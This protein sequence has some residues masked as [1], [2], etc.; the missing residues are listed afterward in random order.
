MATFEEQ[1]LAE[2]QLKPVHASKYCEYS[3]IENKLEQLY[4]NQEKSLINFFDT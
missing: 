3:V 1:K 4:K 2:L